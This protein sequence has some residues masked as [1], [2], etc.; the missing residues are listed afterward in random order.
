MLPIILI[1]LEFDFWIAIFSGLCI[2]LALAFYTT[3]RIF[4]VIN[5]VQ[6]LAEIMDHQS[7][8]SSENPLDEIEE[9]MDF[10]DQFSK[11]FEE[12]VKHANVERTQKN[13]FKFD[14]DELSR[15][16]FAAT[17]SSGEN[18]FGEVVLLP[19]RMEDDYK[20]IQLSGRNAKAS[21]NSAIE[22]VKKQ[23]IDLI[24][25]TSLAKTEKGI[26]EFQKLLLEDKTLLQGV[27]QGI[28]NGMTLSDALD[29][30]FT[31]IIQKLVDSKNAYIAE[32]ANDCLDLK[33]RIFEV[34]FKTMNPVTEDHYAKCKNK[35]VYSRNFF[36][37]E[38]I[39]LHKIGIKGII[40][41]QGTSSS[42]TE[43]LLTSFDIPSLSN[44]DQLHYG[45]MQDKKV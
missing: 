1:K 38:I 4:A 31:K 40:S 27:E 29:L 35:I 24:N 34:I 21:F 6:D 44:L 37:S 33:F 9:V 36:P 39:L 12:K 5:K 10:F 16:E 15:K 43:I 13:M 2:T 3:K 41:Q 23:L 11:N 42:H 18:S 8:G 28:N 14:P 32:R 20:H 26:I 17:F 22:T 25:Y 19:R 30:T 7:D 45:L